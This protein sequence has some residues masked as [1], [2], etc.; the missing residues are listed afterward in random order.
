MHYGILLIAL[1]ITLLAQLFVTSTYNKFLRKNNSTGISGLEAARKIL[2]KNGLTNV[3]VVMS[4]GLMGD[5]YNP[6][7]KTVNLSQEVYQGTSIR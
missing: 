7:T 6:Q 1:A 3:K 4:A 5:H 2:D